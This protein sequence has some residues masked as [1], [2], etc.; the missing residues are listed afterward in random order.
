M[1]RIFRT[2][3]TKRVFRTLSSRANDVPAPFSK[4]AGDDDLHFRA[5]S[6]SNLFGT[7]DCIS[8]GVW[9]PVVY[10]TDELVGGVSAQELKNLRNSVKRTAI[11][12]DS[13]QRN[14]VP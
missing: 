3:N 1:L 13:I 2:K 5:R 14:F 9:V 12:T 8:G 11:E 4:H 10:S 7:G 6:G